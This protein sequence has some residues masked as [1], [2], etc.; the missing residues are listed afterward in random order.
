M[1]EDRRRDA[2][3]Q[4]GLTIGSAVEIDSLLRL[5]MGHVT[6]LLAAERSTLYLVDRRRNEIWSKVL[7][8]DGLREIRLPLGQGVAGDVV[9]TGEPANIADA[10]QDPRFHPEFDRLSG[11]R[12]RNILC[13]PVWGKHSEVMGAVQVL[14]RQDGKAFD[15]DDEQAL[16]A[17]AAQIAVA[18]ENSRLFAAERRKIRELDLLYAVER[19][20]V[21]ATDATQ[22]LDVAL[23]RASE[24]AHADAAAA[25]LLEDDQSALYF[26]SALGGAGSEL[27]TTRVPIN[28][29]IAGQVAQDGIPR[30][31]HDADKESAVARELAQRYGYRTT[32]LCAAPIQA[33]GRILGVLELLNKKDGDDFGDD[34]VKL[35]TLLG[36]QVGRALRLARDRAARERDE[37]LRLL[38]QTM[39]SVLHDLRSPLTVVQSFAELMADETD[40]ARRREYSEAVARQ[41][42]GINQMTREVLAY[43]RGDS[44]FLPTQ[45][46]LDRFLGDLREVLAADF[47]PRSIVLKLEMK[48]QGKIRIDEGKVKRAVINLARNAAEAMPGGGTFTIC[49]WRDGEKVKLSF[50]D[51]GHGIPE[52]VKDKMFEPFVTEGKRDGTGLGLAIVKQVIEAHGG[53][54]Q[55]ES[56]PGKGTT[57]TFSLPA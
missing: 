16:L 52:R 3:L 22:L 2:L 56:T 28:A 20:L 41:V 48:T 26:R 13:A 43:L 27:L 40:L 35:L 47:A 24:L 15:D 14:N 38:G 42:L 6:A 19:E 34:D 17:V 37:R 31:V 50:A 23:A 1:A 21:Q 45:V 7:Q 44:A 10:Y 4:I 25:L 5:V 33:E 11:F 12:T 55:F 46:H 8:G 39:A 29:G 54:V 30:I 49:A 9:A 57:F 53:E 36:G 32:S 18:L 51:T